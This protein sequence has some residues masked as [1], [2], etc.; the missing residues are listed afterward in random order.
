MVQSLPLDSCC[1]GHLEPGQA[2]WTCDMV[3]FGDPC[4]TDCRFW[5]SWTDVMGGDDADEVD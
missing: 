5:V 2:R 3:P 1:A 4:C